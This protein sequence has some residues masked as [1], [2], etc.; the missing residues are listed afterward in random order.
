VKVLSFLKRKIPLFITLIIVFIIFIVTFGKSADYEV[1]YSTYNSQEKGCKALYSLTERLGFDVGR[2]LKKSK[3]LD[4]NGVLVAIKPESLFDEKFEQEDLISWVKKGNVL[5][6]IDSKD[7]INNSRIFKEVIKTNDNDNFVEYSLGDGKVYF[8]ENVAQVQN[9]KLKEYSYKAPL[10]V[11]DIFDKYKDKKIM[12][13][14]YYHGFG[15]Q[16]L[17]FFDTLSDTQ[18]I[19]VLQI[20]L[21][22]MILMFYKSKRF[23]KPILVMRHRKRLENENIYALANVYQRSK[24]Y[25][26]VLKS[27]VENLKKDLKKTLHLT[28][29]D[30]DSELFALLSENKLFKEETELLN[31]CTKEIQTNNLDIVSLTTLSKKID[32][33][34]RELK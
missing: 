25:S 27:Y 1:D 2:Y 29:N 21:A 3:M 26:L 7:I 34:R 16:E 8:Y 6:V 23:G 11:I 9:S 32:R 4:Y 13:D 17:G 5:F 18:F 33:I 19:I 28:I 14:E 15:K 22:I 20:I 30:N 10:D 24:S 31:I 12:F